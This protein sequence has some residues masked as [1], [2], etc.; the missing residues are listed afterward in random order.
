MNKTMENVERTITLIIAR[1]IFLKRKIELDK[2]IATDN[3]SVFTDCSHS[4]A[5]FLIAKTK[6]NYNFHTIYSE[7]PIWKLMILRHRY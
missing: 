6:T 2:L 1:I 7:K 5:N 4:F 3:V